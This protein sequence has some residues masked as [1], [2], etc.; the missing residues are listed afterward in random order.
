MSEKQGHPIACFGRLVVGNA[1]FSSAVL[2]E[3]RV[4]VVNNPLLE[5]RMLL[6]RRGDSEV[7]VGELRC[8]AAARGAIEE[9][10]LDE[11]GL[12]DVFDRIGFFCQGGCKS[13]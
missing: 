8:D 1:T 2:R 13:V 10:D 11:E 4:S 9:S 5:K 6:A 12:V 3:L 7:I